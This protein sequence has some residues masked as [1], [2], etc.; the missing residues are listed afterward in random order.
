MSAW[1]GGGAGGVRER[2]RERLRENEGV[3]GVV[4]FCVCGREKTTERLFAKAHHLTAAHV[5]TTVKY[6]TCMWIK[7]HISGD[8]VVIMCVF[9][10]RLW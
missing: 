8:I 4:C 7:T 6:R 10:Q 5:S 2:E 1:G 9:E 3:C